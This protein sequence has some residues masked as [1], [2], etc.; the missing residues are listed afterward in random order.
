MM[1]KIEICISSG[2]SKEQQP[3]PLSDG[4]LYDN[5]M[6]GVSARELVRSVGLVVSNEECLPGD[7]RD[8]CECIGGGTGGYS[9]SRENPARVSVWGD[10]R[11]MLKGALSIVG[12]D[13]GPETRIL[14]GRVDAH[15]HGAA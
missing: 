1:G 10:V 3:R 5:H 9:V 12:D 4:N 14:L 6:I 13:A 11:K 8:G 2:G 7:W 15:F